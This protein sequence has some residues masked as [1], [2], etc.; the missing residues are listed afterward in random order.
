MKRRLKSFPMLNDIIVLS[1][2]LSVSTLVNVNTVIPSYM[3]SLGAQAFIV[4]LAY[5]LMA[6][7]RAVARLISGFLR[8]VA[9]ERIVLTMCLL[10][11]MCAY[12]LLFLAKDVLNLVAGLAL[13]ATA[14]GL[15][16][17]ALLS[18]T[19]VVAGETASTGAVFGL[20]LTLRMGPNI[21]SPVLS[22]WFA[23][24]F[25][26]RNIFILGLVLTC[27][28]LLFY[29]R[30]K[31]GFKLKYADPLGVKAVF[32]KDLLLLLLATFFLFITVSSFIPILS[33]WIG[34]E[35]GYS[36]LALGL[37]FSSRNLIALFSRVYSGQ[38]SDR[39]GELNMLMCVGLV[40][41]VA[42]L[43]LPFTKEIAAI[44]LL[45]VLH[46]SLMAAPPR[47]A[48]IAKMFGKEDYGKAYGSVGLA[49]DLG[50]MVGPVLMGFIADHYGYTVAY[51][52][53]SGF[54]IA[55][56]FTIGVLKRFSSTLNG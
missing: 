38:L 7:S 21:V 11:R 10:L 23:D 33:Y 37:V 30:V 26:V 14:Q 31:T 1:L 29:T 45:V 44:T 8:D 56:I 54:L 48:F 19:A 2:I 41:A 15:E 12:I 24:S 35:L 32:R 46:G 28:S 39:F 4:G 55:F 25:G 5:T 42:L 40:R 47:S 51:M 17:P 34:E 3:G 18:A 36:Y 16:N 52:S 49:Q 53:M 13:L 20:I 22:G 27:F 6:F 50:S 43:L 9:G